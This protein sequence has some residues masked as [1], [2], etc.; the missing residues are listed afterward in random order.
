MENH[1]IQIKNEVVYAKNQKNINFSKL[2]YLINFKNIVNEL[3]TRDNCENKNKSEK[4]K[5]TSKNTQNKKISNY[6][7]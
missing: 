3:K 4:V 2:N 7:K 5:I 6:K 1:I